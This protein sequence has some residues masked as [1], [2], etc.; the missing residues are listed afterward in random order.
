MQQRC[1]DSHMAPRYLLLL[2][3]AIYQTTY[4]HSH[5][6]WAFHKNNKIASKRRNTISIFVVYNVKIIEVGKVGGC[7]T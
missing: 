2:L 6:H 5:T 3:V 1:V 7:S 4:L